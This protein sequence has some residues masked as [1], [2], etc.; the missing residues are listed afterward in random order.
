MAAISSRPQ[1]VN[2]TDPYRPI[3]IVISANLVYTDKDTDKWFHDF[4]LEK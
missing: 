1:W 2:S 4:N 3:Q